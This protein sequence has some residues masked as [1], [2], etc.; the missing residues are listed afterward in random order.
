[1][2]KEDLIEA[3][4]TELLE[5]KALDLV[6]SS[7]EYEEYELNP[8]ERDEGTAATVEASAMPEGSGDSPSPP[9]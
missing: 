9:S 5:R 6:L 4:A 7:A 2:E 3:L 1:M 8:E